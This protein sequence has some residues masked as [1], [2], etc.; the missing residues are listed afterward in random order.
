MRFSSKFVLFSTVVSLAF[1]IGCNPSPQPPVSASGV[2]KLTV[3]VQTG[4]DGLT[5]EQRNIKY[6]YD[7]DNKPGA[8]KHLYIVSAYSGDCILYSTVDGK[9]TSSGKRLSPTT[10][11]AGRYCGIPVVIG[12]QTYYTSEVCQDDGTYGHS[13]PY[14]IW[15]DSRGF[16]H[17]HYVSGGQIIHITTQPMSWPK[18]ILNLETQMAE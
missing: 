12:G 16:G 10:V 11:A 8:I 17:Q 5:A 15:K 14:L 13:I 6:K 2:K 3:K 9:V 7:E 4:S 1:L 18:I